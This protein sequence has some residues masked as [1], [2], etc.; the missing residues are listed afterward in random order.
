MLFYTKD[1]LPGVDIIEL[2]PCLPQFTQ[3]TGSSRITSLKLWGCPYLIKNATLL[4]LGQTDS[5]RRSIITTDGN[6]AGAMDSSF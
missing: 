4:L 2:C 5:Q 3:Q 6:T 1:L